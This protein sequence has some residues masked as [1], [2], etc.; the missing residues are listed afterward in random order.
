M[1][2]TIAILAIFAW[3]I[4]IVLL[5]APAEFYGPAGMELD[6]LLATLPQATG[7]V[8]IGL[9]VMSWFARNA[10]RQGLLAAFAGNLA[11]HVLSVAVVL[12]TMLIG[13]G[14]MAIT[15]AVAVHLIFVVLCAVFLVR[16]LRPRPQPTA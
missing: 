12:R 13:Q 1:K 16:V 11:V 2:I 5:L 10:D 15:P 14:A 7:A 4:G 8:W 3:L 6:L 9:G